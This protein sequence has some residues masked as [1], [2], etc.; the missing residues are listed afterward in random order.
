ML[1]HLKR[2]YLYFAAG[3]NIVANKDKKVLDLS[4][5]LKQKKE[6]DEQESLKKELQDA[7]PQVDAPIPTDE[8]SARREQKF[9]SEVEEKAGIWMHRFSDVRK[10][11]KGY[12]I[13]KSDNPAGGKM[14]AGDQLADQAIN[15]TP[16]WMVSGIDGDRIN[17]TPIG[18]NPLKSG[19]GAGGAKI[20]KHDID[21]YTGEYERKRVQQINEAIDAGTLDIDTFKYL[22]LG[23]V[24]VN[25]GP[26]GAQGG[27][28]NP[29]DSYSN[30]G[31][32]KGM[33]P[34]EIMM[35]DAQ[36]LKDHGIPVPVK[37]LDGTMD[38]HDWGSWV[39]GNGSNTTYIPRDIDK[40]ID[41]H[42]Q[43]T[44]KGKYRYDDSSLRELYHKYSPEKLD[45]HFD[46]MLADVKNLS[47]EEWK[48]KYRYTEQD[49]A[50]VLQAY[51]W[52]QQKQEKAKRE[53]VQYLT[54]GES[55]ELEAILKNVFSKERRVANRNVA[56]LI[57]M[58]KEDMS[59]VKY[60]H[61]IINL[62]GASDYL[63]NEQIIKF[64]NLVDDI[65]GLKLCAEKLKDSD[66]IRYAL[67][68]LFQQGE[69][70]FALSKGGQTD[71]LQVINS[72]LGNM[73]MQYSESKERKETFG[74]NK[75]LM[76]FVKKNGIVE[77]LKAI[78]VN[79]WQQKH[80]AGEIISQIRRA[81]GPDFLWEPGDE[82]MLKD[83]KQIITS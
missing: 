44:D 67:S 36:T 2:A 7:A 66:N 34:R 32:R 23:T 47:P 74:R 57:E 54:E 51:K 12:F 77:K 83:L 59:Y 82:D 64:F 55:E 31:G 10:D 29:T 65:N 24:P 72:L 22:L 17:L 35:A 9:L 79:D 48:E 25:F 40:Y 20:T 16:Y 4:D 81:F 8:L 63:A 39:E 62:G 33:Q 53:A 75:K 46:E 80:F 52:A 76:D 14:R 70:D 61:D 21:V 56:M 38:P 73:S 3:L 37:A 5:R 19:V 50:S 15:M 26:N 41:F 60:L 78:D 43:M 28:Y 6:K 13:L 71:D 1:G 58:C 11:D 49:T 68:Y 30:R 27:W 45:A 18:S 69:E 42:R